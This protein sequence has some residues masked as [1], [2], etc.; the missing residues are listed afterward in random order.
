[1]AMD[2]SKKVVL[3]TGA[4]GHIGFRVVVLALQAG[5]KVKAAVRNQEKADRISAAQSIKDLGELDD[6]SLTF[7]FVP[8]LLKPGAYDEAVKDVDYIIHIA[9]PITSGITEDKYETHLIEPAVVGTLGIVTAAQ[10]SPSVRRIVITS[11]V[12]AMIPW[13][14]FFEAETDT[15]FNEK[16]RIDDPSG[17]YKSEFEAYAASKVR[18]L[19]ATT[20]LLSTSKPHFDVVH[21][22]PSFVIGKDELVSDSANATAGTNGAALAQVLGVKQQ[23]TT[24]SASVHL[25]DVALAHVK[26]LDP[27]IPSGYNLVL[28]SEGLQGTT[29]GDA[30]DIVKRRFPQALATAGGILPNDGFAPTK[31]T[32]I[33]ASETAKRLGISFKGYE[34]QIV[35]VVGHYLDLKGVEGK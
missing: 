20:Q 5:Y 3:I 21:V 24:P 14:D 26:A 13:H 27:A 22:C 17:P 34:E 35:S 19:N 32:K 23:W 31:R 6:D 10:T 4:N 7:C 8:D 9:S 28:Q 15:V 11:S 25:D 16:S 18:A 30:I 33:D 2:K 29:W 12:V 1:M